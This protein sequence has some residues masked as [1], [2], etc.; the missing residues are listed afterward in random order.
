MMLKGSHNDLGMIPRAFSMIFSTLQQA[1]NVSLFPK[2]YSDIASLNTV[3][4]EKILKEKA[5][6]L[7]LAGTLSEVR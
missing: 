5:A 2:D 4:V 1:S 6:L 7:R 3:E